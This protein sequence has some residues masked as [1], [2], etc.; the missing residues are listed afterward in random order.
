MKLRKLFSY[1]ALITV[2][3]GLLAGC[4]QKSSDTST[5]SPKESPKEVA[6]NQAKTVRVGFFP[7][8]T[9]AQALIGQANGEF[10]KAIGEEHKIE[11]SKFNAGPEEIEAILSGGLDI[12]YIGPGPAVNGYNVSDGEIQII[13]GA[14]NAG[15][16][17]V[18]RKDADIST[19]KDLENKKVAIPQYGN[20][21]DICLRGLLKD[22]GLS[23]KTKGGKVEIVQAKNPDIKTLLDEGKI[24]A[25][26]VPEPWGSRLIKEVGAK[27]I[28]DYDETWRQ[29]NYSL[30]L[31]IARKEF[32]EANPEI[33]ENF[34]KAHIDLSQFIKENDVEAKKIMNEQLYELTQKK[35][36][37]DVLD[38]AMKR[39]VITVNP[40]KESIK[41]IVDL[42]YEAE[43]L[44]EKPDLSNL[45]NLEYLNKALKSKGLEEVK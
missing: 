32:V 14:S 28:L 31:I 20:T 27:V 26:F 8:V 18:A 5:G 39:V 1:V 22:N 38:E 3:G 23:D 16:I 44:R 43:Y 41:E 9:H 17:L 24:D 19:V 11:W 25:A 40:E 21:Q 30:G 34:L 13:S 33:V 35:L 36:P 4:G 45:F 7:N 2:I 10:Q 37:E 29:G 6:K 12:G 42:S 15:A